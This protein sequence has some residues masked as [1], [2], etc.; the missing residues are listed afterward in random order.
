MTSSMHKFSILKQLSSVTD[1][2][3]MTLFLRNNILSVGLNT[4]YTL[5]EK[6]QGHCTVFDQTYIR[7][8]N[9]NTRRQEA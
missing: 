7:A 2:T 6:A 4:S 3:K 9:E 5:A 8:I 1:V